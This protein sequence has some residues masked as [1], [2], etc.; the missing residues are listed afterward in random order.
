MALMWDFGAC[1]SQSVDSILHNAN[2]GGVVWLLQKHKNNYKYLKIEFT[3][4][5][6]TFGFINKNKVLNEGYIININCFRRLFYLFI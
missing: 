6:K 4:Y 1:S 3:I 2:F 5:E